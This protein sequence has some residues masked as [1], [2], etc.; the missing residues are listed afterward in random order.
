MLLKKAL[1]GWLEGRL[2]GRGEGGLLVCSVVEVVHHDFEC[3]G[4]V[5][6]PEEWLLVM[7]HKVEIVNVCELIDELW[8][9]EI[10]VLVIDKPSC[11]IIVQGIRERVE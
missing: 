3:D 10:L 6:F 9:W 4:L 7:R 8:I 5:C 1:G 11:N 2:R